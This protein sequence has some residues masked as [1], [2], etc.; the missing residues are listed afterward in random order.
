MGAFDLAPEVPDQLAA[1]A[2]LIRAA[3]VFAATNA[4]YQ[5]DQANFA[6]LE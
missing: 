2:D 6:P 4:T 1:I 5:E 3:L